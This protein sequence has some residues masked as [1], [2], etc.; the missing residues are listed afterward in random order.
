MKIKTIDIQ[1]KEW[2]DKINGNSYFSA[3]IIINYGMKT[4]KSFIIPFTYGYGEYYIQATGQLL[5][6]EKVIKLEGKQLWQ[7]CDVN[8]IILRTN[9]TCGCKKRDL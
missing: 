2:F 5:E 1:A 3:E 7:Y 9:K 6:K 8:N 4:T